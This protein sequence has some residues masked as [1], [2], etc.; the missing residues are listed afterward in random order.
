MPRS[1]LGILRIAAM[2]GVLLLA[3]V[4]L[5]LVFDLVPKGDVR[6]ILIKVGWVLGILTATSVVLALLAKPADKE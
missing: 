1:I 3:I 5:L 4:A 2:V 6:Q